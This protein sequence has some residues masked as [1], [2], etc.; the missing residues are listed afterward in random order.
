MSDWQEINLIKNCVNEIDDFLKSDYDKT[1]YENIVVEIRKILNSL[2]RRSI[3]K[4]VLNKTNNAL[5]LEIETYPNR[6]ER[7]LR[8]VFYR[9]ASITFNAPFLVNNRE[10]D[11]EKR[12]LFNL[13]FILLGII[14]SLNES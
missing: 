6:F 13:K 3:N 1:Q 5:K 7:L 4:D 11:I 8:H 9:K 2:L 10:G 12:Y 14:N